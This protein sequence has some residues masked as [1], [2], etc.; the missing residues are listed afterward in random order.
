MRLAQLLSPYVESIFQ[1]LSIVAQDQHR[2]ENLARSA[3]GVIGYVSVSNVQQ[4]VTDE[5]CSDLAEAFPNGEYVHFYRNEWISQMIKDTRR[6]RD[7]SQ[8]T[9][10]T[11][12]WT[13]EQVKRQTTNFQGVPMT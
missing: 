6:N 8:R 1:L 10:E 4:E 13:R 11:A 2:S 9:L 5:W 12:A 7:F 3:M